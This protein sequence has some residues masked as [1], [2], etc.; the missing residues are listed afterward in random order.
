MG[1][2]LFFNNS[3]FRRVLHYIL[4]RKKNITL[5]IISSSILK[6]CIHYFIY[7]SGRRRFSWHINNLFA[8]KINLF[9]P[10]VIIISLIVW[11]FN[12]KIKAR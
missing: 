10:A 7:T 3:V 11:L 5:F 8:E 9:I 12:D 2:I 1:I 4:N 6:L